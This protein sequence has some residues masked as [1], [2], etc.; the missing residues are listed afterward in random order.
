MKADEMIDYVLGQVEGAERQRLEQA[1]RAGGEPAARVERLRQAI[2]RLLDDGTPFEHPPEL[3]RRTIAFVAR[4]RRRPL[5]LLE[6]VP[7]RVP[8]RWADFAVAASIFIAGTLTLLP[9]IQ[10][11]RE[12]MN[13]AGCVFNLQRLGNSLAQYASLHPFLP[14]P[15]AHRADA[16]AGTFAAMLH[17]A[18]VLDDPTILDCPCNG[19]CPH[20]SREL[21]SFDQADQ[22]R[23]TDPARYQR[24]LC[25]DY[26]YNVGYRHASGHPG[27]LEVE[28]SA[29]IPV[30]ADQPDHEDSR[31]KDGNSPNHGGRGQ[32]VLLGDGSV[33][34][35]RTR[36]VGPHD[37]D[38]Y[39]N[40][41]R[42]PRP[43]VHVQDSVLVP[44]KTP[45]HG[46]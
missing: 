18:G 16:H 37:P 14:Y 27:P 11:S 17:D 35:F 26:A 1:L 42:L 32:N 38:L 43:G 31:I 28:L 44:S 40:N 6:Y 20:V 7:V 8:F 46:W 36:N 4:N 10:R 12:R 29:R 3:A 30:L 5:T 39:L 41:E 45:F 2:H 24:M 34:W 9:A 13:Q 33:R 19:P 22:I 23:R 21:V 25:W 15:P